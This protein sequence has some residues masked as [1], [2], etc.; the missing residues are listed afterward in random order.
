MG[1]ERRIITV[2][3]LPGSGTSTAC[4]LLGGWS[5]L[6]HVNAGQIFRQ[7]A[8]E[9]GVSLAEYGRQAEEDFRIDRRLDARMVAA[10]RELGQ[11]ILEGRMTGWMAV[12]HGLPAFKIWL[13]ASAQA[14][15][16][17]ISGRDKQPLALAL[18]E[19]TEREQSETRRYREIHGIDIADL[20][21]YD[22]IVDTEGRSAKRVAGEIIARL[23]E[24]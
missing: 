20:S 21:I 1:D 24:E 6:P 16:A 15:A 23:Q 22:L 10:A 12:R 18:A 8:E 17:R 2:S 14:R 11:V 4:R 19:M 7:L 5:G 13:E 3:G 9:A